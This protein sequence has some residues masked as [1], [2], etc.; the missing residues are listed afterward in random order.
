MSRSYRKTPKIGACRRKGEKDFKQE[1]NRRTRSKVNTI[2]ATLHHEELDDVCFPEKKISYGDVWESRTDGPKGYFGDHN[3]VRQSGY[4]QTF[5]REYTKHVVTREF[6]DTI[7]DN[8][9]G[10][11]PEFYRDVVDRFEDCGEFIMTSHDDILRQ[12]YEEYV[13]EC[14]Q[15][16]KKYMRK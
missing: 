7:Y 2:I 4:R 6:I 13:E 14:N 16:Y 1:Y 12:T 15:W 3:D 8:F 10:I 11:T 9:S 5:K